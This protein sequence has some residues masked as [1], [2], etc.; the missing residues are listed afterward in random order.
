MQLRAALKAATPL[1]VELAQRAIKYL[2]AQSGSQ[3][4]HTRRMVSDVSY[5]DDE[6]GIMCHMPS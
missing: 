5:A 3:F 6:G 4:D 1:E 2:R